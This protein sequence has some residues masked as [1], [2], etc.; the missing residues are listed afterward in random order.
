M[1]ILKK[2]IKNIKKIFFNKKKNK[3]EDIEPPKDNYPLW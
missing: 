1:K 3:K 2:I